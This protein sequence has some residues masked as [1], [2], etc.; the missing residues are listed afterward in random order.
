MDTLFH[1]AFHTEFGWMR[2]VSDG[3]ALIRLDWDQTQWSESDNPDDVSRETMHQIN[4]YLDGKLQNFTVPLNP[5]DATSTAKDWLTTM[6]TIPYGGLWTY[7]EFAEAA[8][9]PGAARAAG[10]SCSSNPIPIIYPCHRVVRADRSL[11]NYGGGSMLAP[12]HPSNL[13][14]KAALIKLESNNAATF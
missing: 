12:T 1:I 11:G 13:G 7:K 5:M 3:K 10:T 2:A 6:S 14:R 4:A 9:K 8:G